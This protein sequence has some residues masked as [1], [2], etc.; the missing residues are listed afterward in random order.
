L[1]ALASLY[2]LIRECELSNDLL[3]HIMESADYSPTSKH[4]DKLLI[5]KA[6]SLIAYNFHRLDAHKDALEYSEKG[7]AYCNTVSIMSNLPLLLGRKGVAMHFLG[8][9]EY[10]EYF[11]FSVAL[12]RIQGNHSLAEAYN[13]IY[14]K[15]KK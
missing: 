14:K 11:D 9:S 10:E 12:L 15:Y 3:F 6:Y 13:N 4:V 2:G 1:F 5:S 8:L 7:I